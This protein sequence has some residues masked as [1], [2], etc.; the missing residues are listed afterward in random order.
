MKKILF[1]LFILTIN[2]AYSQGNDCGTKAKGEPI[3]FSKEQQDSLKTIMTVNQPYAI[4]IW[5]TVFANNDGSNRAAS[6]ADIQRQIQN[7]TNQYA[8]HSICFVLMGLTQVNNSD[9][10]NH[11]V[12]PTANDPNDEVGEVVPFYISGYLNIF[13]HASLPGLNGI[14]YNIPNAYLSIW[15]GIIAEPQSG[16]ISTLGHE[17]GHCLGLYHSF[18]PWA[19]ANGVP[20]KRENVARSGSCQNC[21]THGDVLCDTPADDDGGVNASCVYVGGGM[22][23]CGVVFTPMTNNMMGYGFRPC[24]NAFTAG[25]GNR[26]RSFLL[27][28]STLNS[29]L[30]HDV[31][32]LPSS[33]NSS[34][35]WTLGSQTYAARDNIYI[36]NY[37]NNFYNVSGSANQNIVSRRVTL[38]PG[39]TLSPSTGRVKIT[40]NPY[41]N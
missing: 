19:D 5:V 12:A 10:N 4:K 39:T 36:C 31:V 22:D 29:F 40:A 20:T 8:P 14:A 23:A 17:M 26:M 13:V 3:I 11:Y 38:K 37:S 28:N 15:G 32:Y 6:D 21:T 27:S 30:V 33:A 35:T 41:C 24:R 34:I 2:H 25:Q 1:L 7:M 16:N 18:E 9:L